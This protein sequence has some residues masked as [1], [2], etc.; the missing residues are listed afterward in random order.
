MLNTHHGH[1]NPH[2]E[3]Y[4]RKAENRLDPDDVY[5]FI[6]TLIDQNAELASRVDY[7]DSVSELVNRRI[8]KANEQAKRIFSEII[9][10]T[11]RKAS[12]IILE[13]KN[14][15][16]AEADR[17]TA[18]AEQRAEDARQEIINSA[19]REGQVIL[20][21]ALEKSEAIRTSAEAEAKK[22]ID[23]SRN[24]AHNSR[25]GSKQLTEKEPRD[26]LKEAQGRVAR[27]A[28][29]IRRSTK[30]L[31]QR[32]ERLLSS[33]IKNRF[34]GIYQRFVLAPQTLEETTQAEISG[35]NRNREASNPK[36]SVFQQADRSVSERIQI[37]A[38]WLFQSS[39]IVVFTGAG[40]STESGLPD[41]RGPDGFWT[42]QEKGLPA[43]SVADWLD[44][45]PNPAH[46]AIVEL[47]NMGKL[48]FLISQNVDNLH[49]KSGIRPD[50]LAELHG[51]IF[52]VQ[53]VSCG[54]RCDASPVLDKCSNCGGK[55]VST[56]VNFRDPI[57]RKEWA[58]S[59][60][61]SQHCDLFIVVGSS[62]VVNPAAKLPKMAVNAGA[63]L[64]IINQG[65][66][67]LDRFCRLRFEERIG[68]ILPQATNQLK[69]LVD[70][71]KL[72]R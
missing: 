51:N 55:L 35:E 21:A 63:T 72:E 14:R 24:N 66:T 33:G 17:I 45:Q 39:H 15:A 19:I 47:Q 44:V 59:K 58:D 67:Y 62:L 60:W 1:I 56:I 50:L 8:I 10:E 54:F 36:P 53:C 20:E 71:S 27:E 31:Q 18:E 23:E 40:I 29:L 32:A 69:E 3:R 57:P 49:L 30:Q 64:V 11:N 6:S 4:F 65:E 22:I 48:Q 28:F 38:R 5:A 26:I 41:F 68:E 61:H 9:E 52:K 34:E 13:A 46:L 2:P 42:R 7:L 12:A 43:P 70:N 25:K 37:L 16:K